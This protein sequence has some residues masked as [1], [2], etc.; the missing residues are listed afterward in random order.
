MPETLLHFEERF[1]K[2]IQ[3]ENLKRNSPKEMIN[4]QLQRELGCS[5]LCDSCRKVK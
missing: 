5:L 4:Y 2:E 1:A 3:V